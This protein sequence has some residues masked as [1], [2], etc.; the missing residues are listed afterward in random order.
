[1]FDFMGLVNIKS[2]NSWTNVVF[3]YFSHKSRNVLKILLKLNAAKPFLS[4][5]T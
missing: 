1:M 2:K 5:L 3:L 4:E